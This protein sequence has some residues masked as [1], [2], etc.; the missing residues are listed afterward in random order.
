MTLEEKRT[1]N[2]ATRLCYYLE[3]GKSGITGLLGLG[4]AVLGAG[5]EGILLL[6]ISA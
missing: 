3:W 6:L 4:H 2:L 1:F 5:E